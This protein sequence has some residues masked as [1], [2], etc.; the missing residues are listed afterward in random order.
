MCLQYVRVVQVPVDVLDDS[1]VAARTMDNA[2]EIVSDVVARPVGI[3][4][5]LSILWKSPQR[6][7]PMSRSVLRTSPQKSIPMPL[8]VLWSLPKRSMTRN[9][10]SH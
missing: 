3:A 4:L 8:F 1:D 7:I 2:P 5:P 10:W 9:S 6:S